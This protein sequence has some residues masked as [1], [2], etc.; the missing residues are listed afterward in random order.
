[1]ISDEQKELFNAII[2][3]AKSD[4]LALAECQDSSTGKVAN[5]VC[6]ASVV[7]GQL[8]LIPVAEIIEGDPFEK[9]NPPTPG[10]GFDDGSDKDPRYH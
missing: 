3:A 4:Q 6:L 2:V 8:C 9:Y 5:L 10:G 1:M 7:D